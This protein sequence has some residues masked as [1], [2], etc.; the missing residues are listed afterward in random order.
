M[1]FLPAHSFNRTVNLWRLFSNL[2]YVYAQCSAPGNSSLGHTDVFKRLSPPENYLLFAE[3]WPWRTLS[4]IPDL[5]HRNSQPEGFAWCFAIGITQNFGH[6]WAKPP[7]KQ[8][9][10]EKIHCLLLHK[11][12][13]FSMFPLPPLGG[14]RKPWHCACL[15]SWSGNEWWCY[16]LFL[17]CFCS[18]SIPT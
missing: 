11:F 18:A 12:Q 3:E 1:L 17:T 7:C 9:V 14:H 10:S 15:L 6:I 5:L 2:P 16:W 13:T 4:V 8:A